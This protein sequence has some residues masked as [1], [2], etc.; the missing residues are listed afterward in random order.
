MTDMTAEPAPLFPATGGL[1]EATR[2]V[3][4]SAKA[5]PLSGLH[6]W[7]R[8]AL[9]VYAATDILLIVLNGS[10][11]WLINALE[12]GATFNQ[13]QFTA[14]DIATR[15]GSLMGLGLM[16]VNVVLSGVMYSRFIY[17]GITNLDLANARGE[18]MG[19]GWA[20]AYSFIPI[21]SL[22]KPRQAMS[23]IW[24]G[25][26]DP[27]RGSY[28]PPQTMSVWWG[29]WI[30]SN[31]VANISWR[32]ATSSGVFGEEITNFENYKLTLWLDVFSTATSAAA[33]IFL[34]PIVKQIAQAQ[35]KRTVAAKA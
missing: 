25:S 23:Q 9:Y 32:L 3:V 22:W 31:I 13:V 11:I 33:I 26:H 27:D 14:F 29:F 20:V 7:L 15:Y 6:T 10:M 2:P 34:L 19:P 30:V 21:M 8:G 35:D 12:N 5:K 18:R 24:R 1:A 28:E 17:R 4:W 16:V